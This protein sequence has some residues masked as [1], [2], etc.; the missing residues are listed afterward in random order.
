[1]ASA[2]QEGIREHDRRRLRTAAGVALASGIGM[3]QVRVDAY[4]IER[5]GEHLQLWITL[6][7]ERDILYATTWTVFES[8]ADEVGRLICTL[9]HIGFEIA[10]EIAL[11]HLHTKAKF[12]E[13]CGEAL[14]PASNGTWV[15]SN[16]G[17]N[18]QSQAN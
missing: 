2:V 10:G 9:Q 5:E 6:G 8:P 4:V 12:C 16:G 15:H 1:M 18:C 17:Q 13:S 7:S 14:F 3:A 11:H